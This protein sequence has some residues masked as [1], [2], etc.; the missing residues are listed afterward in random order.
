MKKLVL[1]QIFFLAGILLTC[2]WRSQS[3]SLRYKGFR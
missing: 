2:L 1:F 3:G